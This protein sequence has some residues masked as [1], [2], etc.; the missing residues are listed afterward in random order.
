MKKS[1]AF[2]LSL[3]L[4][5]GLVSCGCK[6]APPQ[7]VMLYL[8]NDNADGFV[9]KVVQ[10]DA[11]PTPEGIVAL[12]VAQGA[13]PEGC[14]LLGFSPDGQPQVDM[15]AAFGQ[16]VRGTGTAGEY[17]LFGSLVN[18]L[19]Y[20]YGLESILVTVEGQIPETGHETYD[21]PLRFYEN[22]TQV[23]N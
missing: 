10:T 5:M 18:T 8:P 19:L 17:L 6:I 15:N 20:F 21:Y 1:I 23:S 9:T 22:Q 13:L 7:E 3:L 12:L 11:P 14:A 16:A 4:A 2:A